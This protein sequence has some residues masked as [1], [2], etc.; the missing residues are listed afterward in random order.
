MSDIEKQLENAGERR[1]GQVRA[2]VRRHRAKNDRLELFLPVGWRERL[3]K[4]VKVAGHVTLADWF[5]QI[6]AA[7]IGEES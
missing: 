1:R 4:S 7:E 3:K 6:V 2:G 5:R